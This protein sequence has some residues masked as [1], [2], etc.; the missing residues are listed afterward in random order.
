LDVDY[1]R[2]YPFYC[3]ILVLCDEVHSPLVINVILGSAGCHVLLHSQVC[4][5]ESLSTLG[6]RRVIVGI[7][8]KIE[9]LVEIAQLLVPLA[10]IGA[11]WY[12][13]KNRT[14][15]IEPRHFEGWWSIQVKA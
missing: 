14:Y 4:Q 15:E 2:I 8:S 1:P 5:E 12:I 13:T 10:I 3:P 6:Q 7:F 9:S 11:N